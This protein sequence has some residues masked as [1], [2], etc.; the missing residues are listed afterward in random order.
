[1]NLIESASIERVEVN[2][3]RHYKTPQ[4]GLYPSVTTVTSTYNKKS[5]M[6]WKKRVGAAEAQKIATKAARRGTAV[7][8]MCEHYI[9]GTEDTLLNPIP[10]N[11]EMF[12]PLKQVLDQDVDF[13]QGLESFMYSDTLKVAGTVD[14]VGEYKGELAVID[15][16]TAAK[17]KRKEWIK[18]YFMQGSAYAKMFEE[19]TGH[20]VKQI[21][22]AITVEGEREPQIFVEN[23]NDHIDDF[24]K[25]RQQFEEKK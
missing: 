5:L 21:V 18:N 24:I 2:G 3:V 4:G 1:V 25:L 23:V 9:L 20:S 22:I 19:V 6:E 17:S 15:F 7:H 12:K 10:E 14:C 8:N 16:K 11:V 13:V